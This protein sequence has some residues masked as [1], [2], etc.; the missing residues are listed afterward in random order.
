MR[1]TWRDG[2]HGRGGARAFSLRRPRGHLAPRPL[3]TALAVAGVAALVGF[4]VF[5][6]D[7]RSAAARREAVLQ[8]RL[9]VPPVP[10]P[11]AVED[12]ARLDGRRVTVSGH[13]LNDRELYLS[14]RS[15]YGNLGL[16]VVTPLLREDGGV[17]LVNR[18]WI[19]NERRSPGTR[20]LGQ[21]AGIVTV[22]GIA[23]LPPPRGRFRREEGRDDGVWRRIDLNEM[24]A[25]A[26]LRD[27]A[28]LLIEAGPAYNPG[29][30]PVGGQTGFEPEPD[31][32]RW[33]LGAFGLALALVVAYIGISW[34]RD[35]VD[36]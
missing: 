36:P 30:L 8:A 34:R 20:M 5:Q 13:L 2:H 25:A 15:R 7:A 22:E 19:P 12:A 27:P 31:R 35:P 26:R 18:G 11:A 1:T 24:A 33:A 23:R 21:P 29:G 14:A 10:L 4:G 16:E 9:A 28:P 17:V 6:L 32:L 3:A